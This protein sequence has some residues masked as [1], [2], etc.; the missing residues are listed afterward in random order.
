MGAVMVTGFV[1]IPIA[2]RCVGVSDYGIFS[3]IAGSLAFLLV[4]AGALAMGIERHVSFALGTGDRMEAGR[5]L[6]AGVVVQ[7]SWAALMT[8]GAL[9]GR[10][11]IL[12]RGLNLPAS[13]AGAADTVFIAVL[14]TLVIGVIQS[15]FF[16]L[17]LAHED[18]FIQSIASVVGTC[19]FLAGVYR[20]PHYHGDALV[21]YAL[22]YAFNQ[23]LMFGAVIAFA[24]LHYPEGKFWSLGRPSLR[25]I[26]ELLHSTIWNGVWAGATLFR[27]Q[28][29]SILLNRFFGT[30]LNGSYGISVQT[31]GSLNNLSS[32]V[33]RATFPQIVKNY[34][35]QAHARMER[36]TC[37]CCKYSFLIL[38]IFL[39]PILFNIR[40]VLSLWLHQVP[41]FAA[42]FVVGSAVMILVD[43][44]TCGYQA[45]MQAVDKL[46]VYQLTTSL[47]ICIAVPVGYVWLRKGGPVSIVVWAGVLASCLGGLSQIAFA[48]ALGG[49][50]VQIWLRSVGIPVAI[51]V[52]TVVL[53]AGYTALHMHPGM[54][55]VA[56]T[57]AETFA[58]VLPTAWFSS[59]PEELGLLRRLRP[60]FV[61]KRRL[62][63][64]ADAVHAG[65][66]GPRG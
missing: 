43:Q 17:V 52:A 10:S 19:V 40:Y 61:A 22:L 36:F 53:T 34:S 8:A 45:V 23:V 65:H 35:A 44:T 29:P 27:M 62:A 33:Y 66:S 3:V 26:R 50:H 1:T 18:I 64:Q 56:V 20:L 4:V 15:P 30:V 55:R 48:R 57:L 42:L 58:L 14:A 63:L 38:W 24:I 51:A 6:Q 32:A 60:R 49:I 21:R 5:W 13:R 25:R 37:A 54:A 12:H 41:P 7:S 16:A 31:A 46:A 39:A 47:L 2:I 28:G 11:W 9:L 59:G